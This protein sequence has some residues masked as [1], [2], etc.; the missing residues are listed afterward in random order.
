VL[1]DQLQQVLVLVFSWQSAGSVAATSTAVTP[2]T[3]FVLALLDT[4]SRLRQLDYLIQQVTER[5]NTV[6]YTTAQHWLQQCA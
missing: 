2:V 4:Y 6:Q 1:H 5:A 3:A